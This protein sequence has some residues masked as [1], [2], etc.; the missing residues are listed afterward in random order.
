MVVCTWVMGENP[1]D[2]SGWILLKMRKR[3]RLECKL[4]AEA[5]IV[6]ESSVLV[7][8]GVSGECVG[9]CTFT[10]GSRGGWPSVS[11]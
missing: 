4:S 1:L 5:S 8:S 6:V 9:A 2:G 10:A 3:Q 11:S 7:T